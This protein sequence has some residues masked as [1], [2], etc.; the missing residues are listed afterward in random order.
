MITPGLILAAL[1]LPKGYAIVREED[2]IPEGSHVQRNPVRKQKLTPI[3]ELEKE[4]RP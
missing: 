1:S 3:E 4:D 2:V